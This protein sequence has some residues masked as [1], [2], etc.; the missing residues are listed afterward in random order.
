MYNLLTPGLTTF[1]VPTMVHPVWQLLC[2]AI[3]FTCSGRM[4]NLLKILLQKIF[5]EILKLDCKCV[6]EILVLLFLFLLMHIMKKIRYTCW[7]IL[8]TCISVMGKEKYRGEIKGVKYKSYIM[9]MVGNINTNFKKICI[10]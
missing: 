7:L 10:S 6:H 1:C 9:I 2:C 5:L 3:V 4:F 8:I